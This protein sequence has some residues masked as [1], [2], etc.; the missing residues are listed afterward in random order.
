MNQLY[1]EGR[2]VNLYAEDYQ[3]LQ[4]S[5]NDTIVNTLKYLIGNKQE[6]CIVQGFQLR[7]NTSDNTKFDI[8]HDTFNSKGAII[9]GNGILEEY[10]TT[11]TAQSLITYVSG[12]VVGVYAKLSQVY[13]SHNRK[14]NTIEES[15][16][17]FDLFLQKKVYNRYIQKIEIVQLTDTSYDSLT[18][19]QKREYILLGKF[20]AAGTGSAITGPTLT[21]VNYMFIDIG[22]Q[23]I[24]VDNLVTNFLLPQTMVAPTGTNENDNFY[25]EPDN[26]QDDLNK[27][28]TILR[29]VKQ[30]ENWDDPSSGVSGSI[31]EMNALSRPGIY[32]TKEQCYLLHL[33][34]SLT[35]SF[36]GNDYWVS[37]GTPAY[38][39]T[40]YKFGT[41]SLILDGTNDYLYAPID[42]SIEY[43]TIE[44]YYSCASLPSANASL[45]S[46]EGYRGYDLGIS[47]AGKVYLNLSSNGSSYDISNN[48]ESTVTLSTNTWYHIVLEKTN[49]SYKVYVNGVLQITVTA[50]SRTFAT[51]NCLIGTNYDKTAFLNGFIDEVRITTNAIRYNAAFTPSSLPFTL[52]KP[53]HK[54]ITTEDFP[55]SLSADGTSI[56]IGEGGALLSDIIKFVRTS[57]T[58]AVTA[59][60]TLSVGNFSTKSN[61]E[62]H[63]FGAPPDTYTLAKFTENNNI[64]IY[65]DTLHILNA[66]VTTLEYN[67][68]VPGYTAPEDAYTADAS[69]G[70]ITT[71][72]DGYID[73]NN[74]ETLIFYDYSLPRID[75]VILTDLGVIYREGV[76]ANV[77]ETPVINTGERPL[78]F[79]YRPATQDSI[80]MINIVDVRLS[81]NYR[82]S[83]NTITSNDNSA[84]LS[85]VFN[86]GRYWGV[87]KYSIIN[88]STKEL[89]T[90]GTGWE[91]ANKGTT[92]IVECLT[93]SPNYTYQCI[94]DVLSTD[95]VWLFLRHLTNTDF[96]IQVSYERGFNTQNWVTNTITIPGGISDLDGAIPYLILDKVFVSQYTRI[97]ISSSVAICIEKL[98][99]G[100]PEFADTVNS[101][102]LQNVRSSYIDVD[103]LNVKNIKMLWK[104][105]IDYTIDSVV[106]YEDCLYKCLTSHTSSATFIEAMDAE[107]WEE[108]SGT[109]DMLKILNA[110]MSSNT[111]RIEELEKRLLEVE[112]E[113]NYSQNKTS[114]SS[115]TLVE[116]F[117]SRQYLASDFLEK[118]VNIQS[119]TQWNDNWKY[120]SSANTYKVG[121]IKNDTYHFFL[122]NIANYN[123]ESVGLPF[124]GAL[125]YDSTNKC[126][127][128]MSHNG[129]NA[130]GAI[131]QFTINE[132]TQTVNVIGTWYLPSPGT[133]NQYWAG[134]GVSWSGDKLWFCVYGAIATDSK[135]YGISINKN[136]T[137]GTANYSIASGGVIILGSSTYANATITGVTSTT[138]YGWYCDVVQWDNDNIGILCN[139][140]GNL[141]NSTSIIKRQIL[142]LA[143]TSGSDITGFGDYVGGTGTT[144]ANCGGRSFDKQG[145]T[146]YIRYN[147][148]V[149]I[150]NSGIAKFIIGIDILSNAVVR[151]SG[152]FNLNRII[153]PDS[154]EGVCFGHDGHL[155]DVT[156]T[157][158]F[159]RF[160]AKRALKNALWAENQV[161]YQKKMTGLL[162]TTPTACMRTSDGALWTAD[163]AATAAVSIYRFDPDGTRH[164]LGTTG[165]YVSTTWTQIRD[166]TTDGISVWI[167]GYNGTNYQIM[168]IPYINLN[169]AMNSLADGARAGY[170]LAS[171]GGT[172]IDV[173]GLTTTNTNALYSICYDNDAK[174]LYI[175]NQTTAKIDTLTTG[176]S[177]TYTA[178]VY[179]LPVATGYWMGIA[180]K[181]SN[182]FV[183]NYT[184]AATPNQI[185]VIPKTHANATYMYRSHIYQDPAV[186]FVAAGSSCIDFNGTTLINCHPSLWFYGISTLEDPNTL[187][188]SYFLD[189]FNVLISSTAKASLTLAAP[190]FVSNAT[191]IK[192][193]TFDP[194]EYTEKLKFSIIQRDIPLFH[195]ACHHNTA[196]GT[197]GNVSRGVNWTATGLGTQ[198]FNVCTDGGTVSYPI[199][200]SA[201]CATPY[202]V[203]VYINERLQAA[204]ALN[205]EAYVYNT[206][207]IGIRS[208]IAGSLIISDGSP[209]ALGTLGWTAGTYAFVNSY[210]EKVV[211]S[212]RNVPDYYFQIVCYYDEGMSL[213][214][215]SKFLSERS[216]T[217]LPRYNV[218][219][220]RP[221]HFK[222]GGAAAASYNLVPTTTRICRNVFIDNDMIALVNNNASNYHGTVTFIDLKRGSTL[223]LGNSASEVISGYYYLGTISERND[224]RGWGGSYNP[225]LDLSTT[226][227]LTG[228]RVFMRT[229]TREDESPYYD[230]T[231]KTYMA[232]SSGGGLDIAEIGWDSSHNRTIGRVY[233]NVFNSTSVGLYS[234]YI[235]PDGLVFAGNWAAGGD[236]Y[237]S[238][239]NVW[240]LGIANG[241]TT[242]LNTAKIVGSSIMGGFVCDISPN[243]RCYKTSSGV[244]RHQL[245]VS[246]SQQAASSGFWRVGIVDVENITCEFIYSFQNATVS[247]LIR[248]TNVDNFEEYI[249]TVDEINTTAAP[250]FGGAHILTKNIFNDRLSWYTGSAPYSYLLNGWSNLKAGI[251]A[252]TEYRIH[253]TGRPLFFKGTYGGATVE[254]TTFCR[255]SKETSILSI[256][257]YNAGVQG[258]IFQRMNSS[259]YKTKMLDVSGNPTQCYYKE[260]LLTE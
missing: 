235:S 34:S 209:G 43:F 195:G 93:L 185:Y 249:F 85:G 251:N 124:K 112:I 74:T 57:T 153:A 180:Y 223:A 59:S 134:L 71:I 140:S 121:Y 158:N 33:N 39:T 40:I 22:K 52:D 198:S 100:Q 252:T 116:T 210:F 42:L 76:A 104:A 135:I 96:T 106:V 241:F 148:S 79:I 143:Y 222:R 224:G 72:Q 211:V 234:S 216:A 9:N 154:M 156:S 250:Q 21:D 150:T 119:N 123:L 178:G 167:I 127:W 70:I 186:T 248:G 45:F 256:G 136:G 147:D 179:D 253:H 191:P 111:E 82:S 117:A 15:Q 164:A 91:V 189:A 130:I 83:Y 86:K 55:L 171:N 77:P 255:Y 188:L 152:R 177:P 215:L 173:V 220:I 25:S 73:I 61:G 64:A 84:Y 254:S 207:Y 145:D 206:N 99:I 27:L 88:N 201:L 213:L 87:N 31:A 205:A 175:L 172:L 51:T 101:A 94:I 14:T 60:T 203:S 244:W 149:V 238:T 41:A 128:M 219:K 58:L 202:D 107:Y 236:I 125:K 8:Y 212:R 230:A 12:T 7:V 166:M 11:A 13:A 10:S 228:Y 122:E 214:N 139:N 126:Y 18:A 142:S 168:K 68:R 247:G 183:R 67:R 227:A 46:S 6:P 78:Y 103:T 75:A 159:G 24:T 2:I 30:T 131:T 162:P 110:T 208:K 62:V 113:N 137:L 98:V 200:L 81:K 181:N 243:S 109:E 49:T 157:A 63:T 259:T 138:D 92:N 231:P 184:N 197:A 196:G 4:D 35:D 151:C 89:T 193:R 108:V 232:I 133:A 225:Q 28:R 260:S 37:S 95:Q 44:A 38:S 97:K 36:K 194:G 237:M 199:S 163:I 5:V 141:T 54:D 80:S 182:I 190:A 17:A 105:G 170:V 226:N 169:S 20:T 258:V 132:N 218:T 29:D 90:S 47:S 16:E 114:Y 144:Y 53:L 221:T 120:D 245:I 155:M 242:T 161:C 26:L 240:Q 174:L 50:T 69:T 3:F 192:V 204:G 23:S 48:Q 160:I 65:I 102:N 19:T 239:I 118:P 56:T 32:R 129:N 187:Q 115:N 217:G 246:S 165:A 66:A 146:I 176:E 1:F 229:F 233:K 257:G